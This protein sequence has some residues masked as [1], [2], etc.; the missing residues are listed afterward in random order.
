MPEPTY[1]EQKVAE[2][3]AKIANGE[4]EVKKIKKFVPHQVFDISQTTCPPEDY[5]KIFS[6][7][8]ENIEQAQLYECIKEYAK[9]S[10]FSV[11]EEDMS[12]ISL[13]GYYMCDDDSIH[14][15]STLQDSKKLETIAHELAHGVLHKTST[16]PT[17]IKEFEAESFGTMLKRKLGFPVSDESKRYIQSYFMQS[18]LTTGGKFNM[19]DTLNRLS[20]AFKHI[21]T[22]IDNKIE[23]MGYGSP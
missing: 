10:G 13:N 8:Y 18:K 6:R 2:E 7:G 3:K 11:V 12:S 17:E 5:P 20:K 22:G 16:Q 1:T 9:D 21:S 14:I 19:D 23:E 15:N 4:I